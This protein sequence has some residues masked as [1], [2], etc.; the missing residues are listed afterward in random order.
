MSLTNKTVLV[1]V[2]NDFRNDARVQR[3]VRSLL[4]QKA[5]VVLLG[6]NSK[7]SKEIFD[8]NGAKVILLKKSDWSWKK[9]KFIEFVL[10]GIW[11]GLKF[12]SEFYHANDL[13][14]L[15]IGVFLSSVSGGKLIYD[16]HE[17]YTETEG[18][19]Q[20]PKEQKIWK[21]VEKKLIPFV[22]ETITVCASIGKELE[23]MYKL[24]KV[25]IVRNVSEKFKIETKSESP[26]HFE[27]TIL[28]QGILRKGRGLEILVRILEFLP[29]NYGVA[30]L[31]EGDEVLKKELLD[32]AQE[33]G[34]EKR[35]KFYGKVPLDELLSYTSH[36]D[37]GTVLAEDICLNYYY[38][39]PNKLF[40]YLMAGVP[41]LVSDFPE[42]SN[43]VDTYKVGVK[44]N[45]KN[46]QET[47]EK[48]VLLM[49]DYE[50]RKQ[51]KANCLEASKEL[52]WEVEEKTFL[53][54][55]ERLAN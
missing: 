36:A 10:R 17:I 52:N 51:L 32:L 43:I 18:L 39:L 31:G 45:P 28:Y 20:K 26:F 1:T 12:P 24:P 33:K 27:K 40:Q 35:L 19:S 3:E 53:K 11:E 44:T 2:I 21:W 49:E 38:I 16:S 55:Y 48:I 13:D 8:W 25:W 47:A 29:E 30:V 23:K 5:K 4:S 37:L 14:S 42:L 15:P 34:F 9:G 22:D 6:F 41:V 50:T 54:V 7:N 46:L